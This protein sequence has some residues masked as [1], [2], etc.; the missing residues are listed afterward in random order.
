MNDAA[1]ACFD[2]KVRNKNGESVLN[3]QPHIP[4]EVWTRN[5]NIGFRSTFA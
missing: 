3:I 1:D 4:I 2:C 5:E